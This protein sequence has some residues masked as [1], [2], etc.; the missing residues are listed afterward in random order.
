MICKKTCALAGAFLSASLATSYFI[1]KTTL[2]K[3][4][5]NSLSKGKQHIYQ[6][7]TKERKNI[8]F[9]GMTLGLTLSILLILL[10]R[11]NPNSVYNLNKSQLICATLATTFTVCYFYYILY[12]K[13]THMVLHL[14]TK[15]QKEQWLKI[16]KSMQFN[17]HAG[18]A[19]G[20]VGISIL[21]YGM[22]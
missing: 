8:Y 22:C 5:K 14:D 3:N 21:A 7:I 1:D 19:L 15:N 20:L 2:S 18:F 9:T 10:N 13:S 16:Y 12:P 17:Y 4:L 11:T 6:K